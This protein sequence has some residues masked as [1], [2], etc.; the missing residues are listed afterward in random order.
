MHAAGARLLLHAQGEGTAR[1]DMSGDDL[2]ALITALGWAVDQ[3]SFAPRADHL[4]HLITSAILTS[5]SS[6]DAKKAAC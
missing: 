3:P 6:N 2:F 5:P 1:A 4:V